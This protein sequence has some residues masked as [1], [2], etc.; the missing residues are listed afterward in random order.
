MGKRSQRGE[1]IPTICAPRGGILPFRAR[2]A[3]LVD[4]ADSKS[5][6]RKVVSVRFGPWA[7]NWY[8]R[9]GR[10]NRELKNCPVRLPRL[11]LRRVISHDSS[12]MPC[13]RRR[14]ARDRAISSSGHERR[15]DSEPL[16]LR[17]LVGEEFRVKIGDRHA[18]LFPTPLVR[19]VSMHE[20][21]LPRHP[22]QSDCGGLPTKI[23]FQVH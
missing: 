15:Q 21:G 5:A 2:V 13:S 8:C 19:H 22:I 17:K 11:R 10:W 7:P 4:A 6:D 9:S 14:P 12:T 16:S 3:E 23:T 18:A 1:K 20:T